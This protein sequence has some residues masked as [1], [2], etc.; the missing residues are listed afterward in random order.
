MDNAT[1]EAII[2][3]QLKD[4]DDLEASGGISNEIADYQRH[5]LQVDAQF[6]Q[7]AFDASQRLAI[8][9]AKVVEKDSDLLASTTETEPLDD[10]I[11]ARLSALNKLPQIAALSSCSVTETDLSGWISP[12]K[13]TRNTE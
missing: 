5:Q 2:A 11:F 7:V 12:L 13:P 9:I 10:A 6:D 8:S 4:L 3:I 1:A